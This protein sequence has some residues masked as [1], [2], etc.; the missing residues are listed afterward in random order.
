MR[1]TKELPTLTVKHVRDVNYCELR[2]DC[3]D[4]TYAELVKFGRKKI[5]WDRD[6]MFAYGFRL[7]LEAGAMKARKK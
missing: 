6:A 4:K 5:L 1:R 3:D 2:V 7:A